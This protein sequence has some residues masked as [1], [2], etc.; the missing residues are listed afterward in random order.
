MK[1][2]TILIVLI[3]A[4]TAIMIG[5]IVMINEISLLYHET[6][7]ERQALDQRYE[8]MVG[9]FAESLKSVNLFSCIQT[10]NPRL[11]NEETAEFT[12]LVFKYSAEFGVDPYEIFAKSWVETWFNPHIAGAAGEKGFIQVM[13]GTFKLYLD[14]FNYNID[15]FDDWRCTLKVGIAHYGTLMKQYGHWRIAESIY[16]AGERGNYIERASHHVRKV[17]MAKQRVTRYRERIGR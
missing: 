10:V 3:L 4:M 9:E 1:L 2:K 5:N 17:A 8:A 12:N 14:K 15:D 16:N 7:L 6:E 11:S 13:P